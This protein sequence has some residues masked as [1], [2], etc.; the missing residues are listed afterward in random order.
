MQVIVHSLG[1]VLLFATTLPAAR[2]ATL[3]FTTSWSLLKLTS[4]ESVMPSNH[5]FC[6]SYNW[7]TWSGIGV[8]GGDG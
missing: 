8:R 4:M 5:F 7:T 1:H 3:S 2:Q 6:L